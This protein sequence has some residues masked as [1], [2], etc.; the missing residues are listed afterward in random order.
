MECAA[1]PYDW[2]GLMTANT[3]IHAERLW[4]SI[5]TMAEIGATPKGGCRRLAFSEEDRRGRSLFRSWCE[6]AGLTVR[7][8]VF[9]NMFARRPGKLDLPPVMIGSHLD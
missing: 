6:G 9:G 5:M 4:Q 3:R 1:R 7:V 2:R 8:D